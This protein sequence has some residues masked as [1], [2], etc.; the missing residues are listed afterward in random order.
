MK[1]KICRHCKKSKSVLHFY[2]DNEQEDK[3]CVVCKRCLRGERTR[4][5]STPN[6]SKN[7]EQINEER[8]RYHENK[9]KDPA[10][11]FAKR[12]LRSHKAR[13]Y[14]AEITVAELTSFIREQK[15]CTFCG[16]KFNWLPQ[17]RQDR[18]APSLDRMNNEKTINKD[19]IMLLCR[20]CNTMKQDLPLKEYLAY[21]KNIS[22]K[23][24]S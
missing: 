14:I 18:T 15:H 20:R 11:A 12:A 5:I 10:K 7:E 21:C 13:G 22:N 24:N 16:V 8:A 4:G 6:T 2:C 17:S 9:E 19:N 1:K 3:R 23:F